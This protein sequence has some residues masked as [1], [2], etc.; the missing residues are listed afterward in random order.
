MPTPPKTGLGSGIIGAC[1]RGCCM[2]WKL[3]FGCHSTHT[4]TSQS[5]A[6]SSYT[7]WRGFVFALYCGVINNQ[8]NVKWCSTNHVES[9]VKCVLVARRS[10]N[11][12]SLLV[13]LPKTS[14]ILPLK[15]VERITRAIGAERGTQLIFVSWSGTA[16]S[17][18]LTADIRF[19]G[20]AFLFG[21]QVHVNPE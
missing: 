20:A 18:R 9:C 10:E 13:W 7:L 14:L 16:W 11:L 6:I 15:I 17:C 3:A 19:R 21:L 12:I 4:G 2:S 5:F 1:M 8:L